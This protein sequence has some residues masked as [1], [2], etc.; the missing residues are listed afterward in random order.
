MIS[1]QRA[2]AQLAVGLPDQPLHNR[3]VWF[4]SASQTVALTFDL[5]HGR[6][7]LSQVYL[8][9]ASEARYSSVLALWADVPA[10]PRKISLHQILVDRFTVYCC[11]SEYDSQSRPRELSPLGIMRLDLRDRRPEI[12][13]LGSRF[14]TELVGLAPEEQGVYAI[15][16]G[17]GPGD[18]RVSYSLCMLHWERRAIE[19]VCEFP[20]I[21]F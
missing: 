10:A 1:K 20:G 17:P 9:S 6:V 15:T 16:A 2:E 14:A 8:R 5:Y 19:E 21:F 4:D 12:W 13:S 11:V 7:P 3:R 18:G